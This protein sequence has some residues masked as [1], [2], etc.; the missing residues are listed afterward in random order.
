[1]RALTT[2]LVAVAVVLTWICLEKE[3]ILP[4][5][6]L[7]IVLELKRNFI[8]YFEGARYT[9]T[10]DV[11]EGTEAEGGTTK[12]RSNFGNPGSVPCGC[13]TQ[14]LRCSP[15]LSSEALNKTSGFLRRLLMLRGELM[16]YLVF[17]N[18]VLVLDEGDSTSKRTVA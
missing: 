10:T 12:P 13:T 1:M 6:R 17:N 5:R 3:N 18:E 11:T 16:H 14:S 8:E 9:S 7:C 2:C 15:P 4:P